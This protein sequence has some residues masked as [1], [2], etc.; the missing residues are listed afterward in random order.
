LPETVVAKAALYPAVPVN[1]HLWD[2]TSAAEVDKWSWLEGNDLECEY[3]SAGD[4]ES[5]QEYTR[6][7]GTKPPGKVGLELAIDTDEV[8]RRKLLQARTHQRRTSAQE[9]HL[10][11]GAASVN[12]A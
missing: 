5:A 8:I 9:L 11:E 4:E 2:E 12:S 1:G 3:P 7:S 6:P 10:Q